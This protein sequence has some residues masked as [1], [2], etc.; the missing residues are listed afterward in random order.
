MGGEGNGVTR[1][2]GMVAMLDILSKV[3]ENPPYIN[4]V[5]KIS[6]KIL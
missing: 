4:E 3:G 5:N 1:G 6:T 2:L